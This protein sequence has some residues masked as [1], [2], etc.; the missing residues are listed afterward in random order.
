MNNKGM[1]VSLAILIK[2][3]LSKEN[4]NSTVDA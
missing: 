3:Q 1:T 4:S 2:V